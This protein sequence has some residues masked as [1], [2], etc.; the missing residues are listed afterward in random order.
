MSTEDVLLGR[1]VSA[2]SRGASAVVVPPR[3]PGARKW[4]GGTWSADGT[5]L[6]AVPANAAYV[7]RL[8]SVTGEVRTVETSQPL[9]REGRQAKFK[10]LRGQKVADGRIFCIPACA[11]FVLVIEPE[12]GR[13]SELPL[14]VEVAPG[15]EWQWHGAALGLDGC[16]YAI[17]AGATR[18]LKIDPFTNVCSL[19]G[20]EDLEPSVACKWYGGLR[21]ADGCIWAI[22][23]N[24]RKLLRITPATGA[25]E[26][27]GE[28]LG[29]GGWKWHGGV[30]TGK[31]V[32]GMP[33]HAERVLRVN[34]E[35]AEIDL[36]GEPLVG[37]Y[38]WGGGCVDAEGIAWGLPSNHDQV[39][40]IDAERGE[41]RLIGPAVTLGDVL[42][43]KSGEARVTDWQNSWQGYAL[44]PPFRRFVP[45]TD[46]RSLPITGRCLG[47]MVT[48]TAS[49]ATLTTSW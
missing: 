42:D 35:T 8:D 16:I 12:T 20:D 29:L 23:F 39:I 21:S 5:T 22:P 11:G 18:V 45:C 3:I 37:K 33:S 38:K 2:A 19:L 6:W 47:R 36:V 28:D 49:P 41:T 31:Y 44:L 40:R 7:L 24:A 10:Y 46:S 27:V 48:C 32:I 17:P 25:V 13:T 26:Q 9:P 4:L 1:G 34:T 14:P 43:S 30:Q 15:G